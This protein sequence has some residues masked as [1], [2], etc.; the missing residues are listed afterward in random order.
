MKSTFNFPLIVQL[1]LLIG[2]SNV[3][4]QQFT[5]ITS[6][7]LVNSPSGS[8]SCNFLDVNNDDFQDIYI[9]NGK[10]GGENNQLYINNGD[11]TF[12]IMFD[13][14]VM[15]G[16]PTDGATCADYDNDG[17]IDV[18]AVNWYNTTNL[19]YKNNGGVSFSFVDT[20]SVSSLASYSETAAWGDFNNDGLLDL[21]VTN[22]AGLKRNY[23]YQNMGSGYFEPLTGIPPFLDN[24]A[25]RCVNWIDFDGDGDQDLFVTN[26]NNQK[27]NLYRN[28]GGLVFT[29][30][31]G[32]TIVS[33]NFSSMSGSWEDYDNDGDFDLFVANYQQN[34]QLFENDGL[35]N[36]SAIT[37]PWSTE[38]DCSFSASFADCDND[39]DLDLFVTNG[40]CANDLNNYLYLNNGDGTFAKDLTSPM[41]TAVGGSY[42]CAWG[43]Y[44]NDGWQDLVVANWQGEA[45]SNYLFRNDGSGKNW[46][47]IKLEGTISNRSAIGAVV[48]CKAVINGSEIWQTR[49]VSSQTGYCSQ[50][51]LVVHFGLDEA[52]TID[53]LQIEWPSGS[54]EHFENL[55]SN[56]FYSI[57][58]NQSIGT[59]GLQEEK[60]AELRVF[61][62]PSSGRF[63]IQ[64]PTNIVGPFQLRLVDE[65]GR[66]IMTEK[67]Q[68][69]SKVRQWTYND[70]GIPS[71]TYTLNVRSES[72]NCVYSCKVMV[73][74]N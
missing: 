54:I 24:F 22:S 66:E 25:S 13:T 56:E 7:I 33:D 5:Q 60:E 6:G 74:K 37:G 20:S 39:G 52:T 15:D 9:T 53:S 32:D 35:G 58:E 3:H 11:G 43:D 67:I 10:T 31:T 28:D 2:S 34:N 73:A 26:E 57:V 46:I 68:I 42:G 40:Y 17:F 44:N 30:V 64:F 23:L 29:P 71:G 19:L 48:R 65:T 49:L 16:S 55:M 51:S 1:A 14:I 62:N 21:Y 27:N 45:Q 70:R 41:S 12:S 59:I 8:R 36:F 61:P 4:A 47:K 18:C 72:D 38:T 50:N 69:D 63:T